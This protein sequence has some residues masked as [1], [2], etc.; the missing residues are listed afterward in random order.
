MRRISKGLRTTIARS[1]ALL[2]SIVLLAACG[3]D[4]ANENVTVYEGARL[5]TGDGSAPI[6]DAVFLVVNG[7]FTEVGSRA[8]M[9]IPRGATRVDLAGKTVM[10]AI[11]NAH[12]HPST[13]PAERVA[14]LQHLAYYGQGTAVSMGLDVGAAPYE[15]REQPPLDGARTFIA[16]RGITSPEPGRTEVPIW[17][18][19]PEEAR[20]AVQELAAENV[21]LVKIW[22]DDRNGQYDKLPP[23][24]YGPVIDE[25]HQHGLKVAAHIYALEDAKGLLRAG[26][27]M[28]AHSVRDQDIDDELLALW[29]E[30]PN[31]FLIPNLTSPGVATDLSWLAGTVPADQLA[32]MQAREADRPAAQELFGIQARGLARLNAAGMKIA[33]GTDG[34]TP[35]AAHQEMEDMV[36]GGM[37][38]AEVIHSATGRGAEMLDMTDVGTVAAGKSADFVVLDANPLADI[39]NTRRISAVYLR[40]AAIDREAL[41]A[42]F[43]GATQ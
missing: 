16:G 29:T 11:I 34:L 41:G 4:S 1:A 3:S 12:T 32:D 2:L 13:D 36:R 17:I 27:D 21:D 24:L 31:T 37:T 43:R 30:R 18:T 9:E 23:E 14:Q 25:A 35:W 20:A 22:V 40:G 5:I 8:D 15:L 7:R 38:P 42:R 28:F 6:E 19:T 33:M 26:I 39:T 10:P